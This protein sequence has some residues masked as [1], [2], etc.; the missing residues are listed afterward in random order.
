MNK[1]EVVLW[2]IVA[3][4]VAALLATIA[5]VCGELAVRNSYKDQHVRISCIEHGGSVANNV[6]AIPAGGK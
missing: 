2:S 1:T 3:I 4:C 6:C 5:I